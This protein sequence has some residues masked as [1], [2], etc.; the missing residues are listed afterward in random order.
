M[1]VLILAVPLGLIATGDAFG[2]WDPSY[3]QQQLGYVPGGLANLTGLWDEQHA[4][5]P[6]YGFATQGSTFMEETPG[7]YVSAILG[8]VVIGLLAYVGF[9]LLVR[10][11]DDEDKKDTK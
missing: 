1:I 7:Y 6:G 11:N 4:P 3:L 2:E 5:L 10:K 8:C 9:T